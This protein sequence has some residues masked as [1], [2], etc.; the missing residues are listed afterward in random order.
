MIDMTTALQQAVQSAAKTA[1]NT[2]GH[3]PAVCVFCGGLG[4]VGWKTPRHYPANEVQFCECEAGQRYKAAEH[5]ALTE[6]KQ[7]R[8]AATFSHAGIPAH[9]HGLTIDT[10][11]ELAGDDPGKAKA[12]E[13]ARSMVETGYYVGKPG[14]YLFGEYGCGKT[15]VLTPVLRHYLDKGH[16]GLWMEFYDF[17]EE[18]QSK[19]GKGDEAS[20]AM[21]EVRSVEWLLMDDVGD[22]ARNGA[23][24]DD[25]RKLLYQIVNHR[26][27]HVRPMLITS[28]LSP[29]KFA[30]QFGTRTLERIIESCAVVRIAGRNL[31]RNA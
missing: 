22:V 31:R 20:Q 11:A 23:E 26:H 1:S 17:T 30:A 28:N 19:Y 13:A 12:I 15:G 6:K 27:N 14:I 5:Q 9:F 7:Q 29:D 25:K 10:L 24:T 21:D 8:L 4:I 18:I 16:S 2:N 3:G